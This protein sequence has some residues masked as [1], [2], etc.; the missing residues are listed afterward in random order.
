M[1]MV[2]SDPR[3]GDQLGVFKMK[4]G[5]DKPVMVLWEVRSST[6]TWSCRRNLGAVDAGGIAGAAVSQAM[7]SY[8]KGE[9]GSCLLYDA[10]TTFSPVLA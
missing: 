8:F 7:Q 5:H 2:S 6:G 3:G 4:V 9:P 10:R 1:E